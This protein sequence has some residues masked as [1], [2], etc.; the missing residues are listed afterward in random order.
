MPY[1]S[2]SLRE[3][4]RA[5]LALRL[6][7]TL[8]LVGYSFGCAGT[9]KPADL[10]SPQEGPAKPNSEGEGTLHTATA[11]DQGGPVPASGEQLEFPFS[12]EEL[13]LG[14]PPGLL[15][16]MRAFEN[17]NEVFVEL[18]VA[19]ADAEGIAFSMCLLQSSPQPRMILTD[20]SS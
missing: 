17:G 3:P 15:R 18:T 1:S 20:G 4:A 5:L 10:G 11:Q 2:N 14:N 9:Q 16:R 6:S 12:I 7:L 8:L 19:E 13:R